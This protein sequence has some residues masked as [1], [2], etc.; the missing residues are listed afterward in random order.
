MHQTSACRFYH[1]HLYQYELTFEY[2]TA[3]SIG[4]A[5]DFKEIK[6][7]AGQF[8]DDHFDHGFVANPKDEPIIKAINSTNSRVWYMSLEGPVGFC[9]PTAEN[10]AKELFMAVDII[11]GSYPKL[12][13]VQV[14]LYETPNCFV[15]CFANSMSDYEKH[16]FH[17]VR[18]RMCEDYLKS[19]GTVQYDDRLI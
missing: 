13:L 19:K 3:E 15:D 14:R 10:I 6:R 8:I 16:N 12:K 1:G 5:I 9:N 7:I 4:Y 18:K 11:M 2:D 17:Q